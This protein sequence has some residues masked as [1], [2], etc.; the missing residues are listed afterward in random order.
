[1]P[2]HH[3]VRHQLLRGTGGA[4]GRGARGDVAP[5]AA[6]DDGHVGAFAA[7]QDALPGLDNTL[8]NW[9]PGHAFAS[10]ACR[11][12]RGQDASGVTQEAELPLPI[13]L[14]VG[15]CLQARSH[16][17]IRRLVVE[18]HQ[19]R[20]AVFDLFVALRFPPRLADR[21]L[22]RRLGMRARAFAQDQL[23]QVQP[24]VEFFGG[25][26]GEVVHL[27]PSGLT[28]DECDER[29]AILLVG[30]V[31]IEIIDVCILEKTFLPQGQRFP[32]PVA[33]LFHDPALHSWQLQA[34]TAW[35]SS[36]QV[37]AQ[38]SPPT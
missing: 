38:T 19:W 23:H 36:R 35:A 24:F 14:D 13:P 28:H 6:A 2:Q 34:Y 9:H 18:M 4:A 33:I 11:P 32:N 37:R 21:E 3:G 22:R 29:R 25:A 31:P 12:V 16:H 27:L 30:A 5:G 15:Q 8:S 7:A 26:C 1:M 10:M 17:S 20:P